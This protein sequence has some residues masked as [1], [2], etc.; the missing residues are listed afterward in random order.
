MELVALLVMF[1]ATSASIV[2][3]ICTLRAMAR[4]NEE[5]G[6]FVG[7]ARLPLSD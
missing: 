4:D 7:F 3:A 2:V 1:F 6:R 5:L